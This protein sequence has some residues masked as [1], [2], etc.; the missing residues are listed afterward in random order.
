MAVC[1]SPDEVADLLTEAD[2]TIHQKQEL[3][4]VLIKER[5]KVK[6]DLDKLY[7]LYL[8]DQLPREGFGQRTAA[9]QARF[10]Q[11][12]NEIP[13]LQ[14]ETDF[15]KI[16]LLSRDQI[17]HEASDLYARWP[18]LD[19]AE[20]RQIVESITEQIVIGQEDITINLNYLPVSPENMAKK[21]QDVT[22]TPSSTA[23]TPA[24]S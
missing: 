12:E 15:L 8:D 13:Q 7:E 22:A 23:S 16:N 6:R 24:A 2:E 17:L 14:A 10:D 19:A 5:D 9:L 1:R 18:D 20:K 11:L 21:P 3:L 4:E